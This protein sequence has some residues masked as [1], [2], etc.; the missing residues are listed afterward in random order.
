V[1]TGFDN[2]IHFFNSHST[3]EGKLKGVEEEE[4]VCSYW[5]TLRK[6]DSTELERSSTR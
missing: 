4:D 5:I 1:L 3:T 2:C 6:T